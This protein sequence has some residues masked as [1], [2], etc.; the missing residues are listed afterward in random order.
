MALTLVTKPTEEPVTLDE[1][2]AHLRVESTAEDALIQALIA[3]AREYAESVTGRQLVTA[4][5]DLKLDAFPADGAAIELPK[6][7]LRSIT[8]VTYV[9]TAGATQ[10]WASGKYVVDAPSGPEALPGRL[11][12]AY[13]ESYPATRDTLNA[14]TIRFEAGYGTAADVPQ[15]IKQAML[16]HIGHLYENR[17]SVVV[18]A[19][20]GAAIAVPQ[21]T[22]WLLAPYRVTL[23]FA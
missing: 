4:T 16:L 23:G 5:W 20:A 22:D 13:G 3:A 21:A 14:V 7:P 19:G 8:S 18:G 9:D 12:P 17:Q 10:T 2:K 11:A 6:A 1:A 15:A